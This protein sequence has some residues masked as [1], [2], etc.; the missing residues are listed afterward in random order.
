MRINNKCYYIKQLI[1]KKTIKYVNIGVYRLFNLIL[2]NCDKIEVNSLLLGTL[3]LRIGMLNELYKKIIK[4]ST[5]KNLDIILKSKNNYSVNLI[6]V[7]VWFK[8]YG[9]TLQSIK[10]FN[11]W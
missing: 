3:Y 8:Y 6:R 7:L 11:K 9:I 2:D 4:T 5:S 10:L 1:N